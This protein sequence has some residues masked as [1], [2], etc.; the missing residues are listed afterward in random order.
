MK[1]MLL[2]LVTTLFVVLFSCDKANYLDSADCT[3]NTPTY[4]QDV[5]PIMAT[6]CAIT[7][8]HDA[9]TVAAGIQLD[10]YDTVVL[11]AEDDHFLCSINHGND[12]DA[13]PIGLP[14]L[15]DASIS[16]ITCWIKNGF[17]E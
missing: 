11:N 15:S 16:A 3:D 4:T 7:A 5:A 6:S 10:T 2:V 13:M 9:A 1:K 14:K 8:C 17:A 12:C